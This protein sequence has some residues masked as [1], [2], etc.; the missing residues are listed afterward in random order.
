[1]AVISEI[2]EHLAG[3]FT[4]ISTPFTQAEEVDYEALRFNLDYYARSDIRGYLALGS[5]GENRSLTEDEKLSVL[6][7]ITNLR[8]KSQVVLAG[9]SYEAQ[10]EAERF[11]AAAAELG[12]DYGLVLAPSYFRKQMTDEVLYRYF[13]GLAQSSPIPILVYNAP[14]FTGSALSPELVARLSN[15]PNIVGMKDSASSGIENYLC[16]AGNSFRIL[17]GSV[18]LLFPAVTGGAVGGTVSLANYAPQ[19]AM[20]LF[21]YASRKD[22]VRGIPLQ[23]RAR[24]I[25]K[26]ISG[27]YGVPG[28]KAAMDLVGL[29]GG[30]P[31]RPL[32]PLTD[33]QLTEVRRVLAQEG[34]IK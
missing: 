6:E 19:L 26:I 4:P 31:R 16:V 15:E 23:A 12:A 5:N 7:A 22:D 32:L 2:H 28:V 1:M 27:G 21:H 8:G 3:V 29:K 9:A 13:A 18:N 34:L 24:E 20:E 25:N 10:R 14:Q 17:A 33:S 11:L 30:I